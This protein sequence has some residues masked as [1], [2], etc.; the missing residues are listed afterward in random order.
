MQRDKLERKETKILSEDSEYLRETAELKEYE[1]HFKSKL[2]QF[3][4]ELEDIV[5]LEHYLHESFYKLDT[6]FKDKRHSLEK[7]AQLK[8]EKNALQIKILN[9]GSNLEY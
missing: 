6:T 7:Q 5:S 9:L 8:S 1:D 3:E 4:K 2:S